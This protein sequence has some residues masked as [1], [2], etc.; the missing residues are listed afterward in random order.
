MLYNLQHCRTFSST[1]RCSFQRVCMHRSSINISKNTLNFF[2]KDDTHQPLKC[3]L[4]FGYFKNGIQ[5]KEKIPNPVAKVALCRSSQATSTWL[6]LEY[7]SKKL[8]T[9]L[10]ATLSKA[11][12]L[13][14]KGQLSLQ[15]VAL[16]FLRSTHT[17]LEQLV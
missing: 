1:L 17:F 5:W 8:S 2:F 15:V 9:F 14:G 13:Q 12:S 7:L 3:F 11:C 4:C 10:A 6:Y 16:T